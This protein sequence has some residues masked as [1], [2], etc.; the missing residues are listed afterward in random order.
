MK[1][2]FELEAFILKDGG[3]GNDPIPVLVPRGIPKDECG[4][5][6]E[7]RSEPHSNVSKAIALFQVDKAEVEQTLKISYP[8]LTLAYV[9][10]FDIPRDLKVAARRL[11][12]KGTLAYR[13]LYGHENHRTRLATASMHISFTN[14]R[15]HSYVDQRSFAQQFKYA[16]FIDHAKIIVG[17]DKAFK[18]EIRAAGRN[19]GFYE[20]KTDGRIEYR[21]LPNDVGFKK[22]QE[23]LTTLLKG[24]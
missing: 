10:T 17:L 2:G 24:V 8:E 9:P 13:N 4:W 16:G 19:P 12:G 18:A 11:T 3:L 22:V 21:S 6:V 7:I 20:V 1:I 5:L 23:V 15:V 14:E